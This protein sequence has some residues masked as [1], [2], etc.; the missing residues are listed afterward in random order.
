MKLLRV[1]NRK[2]LHFTDSK[3]SSQWCAG[4]REETGVWSGSSRADANSHISLENMMPSFYV[5][6]WIWVSQTLQCLCKVQLAG[7]T[8]TRACGDNPCDAFRGTHKSPAWHLSLNTS[9]TAKGLSHK[10]GMQHPKRV[11]SNAF[12]VFKSET[13]CQTYCGSSG[14]GRKKNHIFILLM[15]TSGI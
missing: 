4:E 9:S 6:G 14:V 10:S 8:L 15:R 13:P 1:L 2:I 7:V 12:H 5:S 3:D 11:T